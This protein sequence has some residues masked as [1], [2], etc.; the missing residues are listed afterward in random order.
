MHS[1]PPEGPRASA[2]PDAR[3][4]AGK[5]RQHVDGQDSVAGRVRWSG[6][7]DHDE[8]GRERA[9]DRAETDRCL[10]AH[11]GSGYVQFTYATGRDLLQLFIKHKYL[12]V[13]DWAPDGKGLFV[14]N[15]VAGR[16]TLL[17]VD[18]NGKSQVL[19]SN[20][21]NYLTRGVPSPD[22]RHIALLNWALDGNIWMMEHF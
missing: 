5:H 19:Q 2:G 4:Q 17:Y 7:A 10:A 18:L 20:Y 21:G 12:S 13:A 11:A 16:A 6:C 1:A 22:G 3:A 9:A 14:S 8:S 15:V